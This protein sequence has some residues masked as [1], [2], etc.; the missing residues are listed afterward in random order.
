M[1]ARPAAPAP[2]HEVPQ[3]VLELP[4]ALPSTGCERSPHGPRTYVLGR[5]AS[6]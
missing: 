3:P 2:Y 4:E 1:I 6:F 5:A